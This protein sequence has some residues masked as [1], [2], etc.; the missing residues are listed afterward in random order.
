M[1][2]QAK[3]RLQKQHKKEVKIGGGEGGNGYWS[4]VFIYTALLNFLV[5]GPV[6]L[7]SWVVVMGFRRICCWFRVVCVGV[8]EVG[9]WVLFGVVVGWFRLVGSGRVSRVEWRRRMRA[10][11]VCP[12]YDRRLRRCRP[13]VGSSLGCGCWMPGKALYRGAGCWLDENFEEG[14]RGGFGWGG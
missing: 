1:R 6:V 4:P 11:S 7:L 10:C 13:E 12:V 8:G 9:I 2:L 3:K 5:C 14:D